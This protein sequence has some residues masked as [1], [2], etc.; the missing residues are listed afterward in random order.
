MMIVLSVQKVTYIIVLVQLN[1][2][3][4]N[5]IHNDPFTIANLKY[6]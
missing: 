4:E 2:A 5:P 1:P 3:V 6:V